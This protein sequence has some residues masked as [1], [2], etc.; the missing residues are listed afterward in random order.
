MTT[1]RVTFAN[2]AVTITYQGD[3]PAQIVDFL[4]GHVPAE[5][6]DAS[7][8]DYR[9]C[10][11]DKP[12]QLKLYRGDSLLYRGDS[13][14]LAA[15][16]LLGDSCHHLAGRSHGGLLLHAAGLAWQRRGLLLPGASGS[17]KTTLTAWLL[18][19]G[20]GYLSDELVFTPWGQNF[21][22]ALARPLN[23]KRSA[24]PLWETNLTALDRA[25]YI[26]STPHSDLVAPLLFGA[27]PTL[28][29]PPLSL[30][31]FPSYRPDGAGA[32]RPLSPAQAGL[33]LMQCLLNAR[34]LP[35]HGF[36]EVT[37]LARQVPAYHLSYRHFSQL[38][39]QIEALL[40][41][42]KG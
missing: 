22:Q 5:T 29:Q 4:Y 42:N 2:S 1:R 23:L 20:F 27:L 31:I 16:L 40:L 32:L 11:G 17:G 33:A 30:I 12:G 6:G 35:E 13:P 34:N 37:R 7:P 24:R 41:Q 9:L 39:G 36:T 15:E 18:G 3:L 26:L 25:R 21:M 38:E 10:C 28:A 8:L 19:W 14:A